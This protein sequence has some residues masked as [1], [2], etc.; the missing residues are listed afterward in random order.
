MTAGT[1]KLIQGGRV[2]DPSQ[3]LDITGDVLLLDDRIAAVGPRMDADPD[4]EVIDSSGLIVCPGL[5]DLHTHVFE[6]ATDFSVPPDDAGIGGGVTTVVDM[7]TAGAWTLPGLAHHIVERSVT[8][9]YSFINITLIGSMQGARGGPS[10]FNSDY[11]DPAAIEAMWARYPTLIKGIKTY[12]ESGAWS[13]GWHPFLTKAL[14]GAQRTGLPLYIHTGELFAVDEDH[15]PAPDSVMVD[16]LAAA[17]PGDILGHC[18]S[19][20]PDGILGSHS[21]PTPALMDA[22]ARGVRLDIGHG[23]NFS[24]ETARRMLDADLLPWTISSDVHGE[25]RGAHQVED[26]RWSLLGTISKLVALGLPLDQCILRA[27]YH[28]A[29]VL[30]LQGEIG[31]LTPGSRADLSLIREVVQPWTFTDGYGATLEADRR[32]LPEIV[33]RAGAVHRPNRRL[34]YDIEPDRFLQ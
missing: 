20:Q 21:A 19:G 32:F 11:V 30:E 29:Q 18:Y 3:G 12:A 28:P 17:R 15:R 14:E 6:W 27:T 24:F 22:V 26:C 1:K 23:L 34:L 13:H 33:I 31:S 5:V 8:E 7:G 10:V 9:I 25:L 4:T 2:L 16:V